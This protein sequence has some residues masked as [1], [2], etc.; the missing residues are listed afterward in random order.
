MKA[1]LCVVV[2]VV[3]ALPI[4]AQDNAALIEQAVLPLPVSLRAG[5]TVVV[6]DKTGRHVLRQGTNH[7]ICEP[8]SPGPGFVVRCYQE[9]LSAQYARITALIMQGTS[10]ADLPARLDAEVKEGKLHAAAGRT[11]YI[12]QGG[13]LEGALPIMTISM[14][15]ATAASTGLGT[16]PDSQRPWLMWAGTQ[17]AH[18]MIP[19][20]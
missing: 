18:V 5:A 16:E 6:I 8:D 9:D 17:V 15:G 1:V 4:R 7:I 3:V 2:L 13:T 12:I 11:T 19:G 10:P 14:P 20:K